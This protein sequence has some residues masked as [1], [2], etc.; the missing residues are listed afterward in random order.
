MYL[1][2][3][4]PSYNRP[5]ELKRLIDSVDCEF[6]DLEICICEDN[7][8]KRTEV[9]EL[10]Q[11]THSKYTLNYYENDRNLGYDANLRELITRAQGKW[12]IFMGDDDAFIPGELE[13]FIHFLKKNEQCGYVLRSYKNIYKDGREEKFIYYD[14][15]KQFD[16]GVEGYLELYRKST[17]ISGFTFQ[18]E[19]VLNTLTD[20]FD[21]TLLYQLYML[22]ELTLNYPSAYYSTPFTM[23]FEGGEFFFG[24]SETE[25]KFFKPNTIDV[26]GQVHFI[27]SYFTI[28]EF[29]DK[30]YKLDSTRIIKKQM[31][32]YSYPILAF[33]RN[34]G[35]RDFRDFKR[36]LER[37]GLNSSKLFYIYYYSL[38]IF[39]TKLT[40]N[41]IMLIKKIMGRTPHL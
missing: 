26:A 37:I 15:D 27:S 1:S 13:K 23:A 35:K 11:N 38:L 4:I 5:N 29:I 30:K 21:S 18:R 6:I 24:S 17:F 9:R 19:Y 25:K 28:T 20:R 41:I 10:V 12:C 36:E 39:G 33:V 22:A 31:S 32:K 16:K 7:A 3:C 40:K 14:G 2:I 34:N 8:P